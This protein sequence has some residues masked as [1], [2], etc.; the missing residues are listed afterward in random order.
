MLLFFYTYRFLNLRVA[1]AAEMILLFFLAICWLKVTLFVY[2]IYFNGF[3]K[4][5][6]FQSLIFE[7]SIS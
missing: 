2:S 4:Y 1:V 3:V 6:I 7:K 5:L